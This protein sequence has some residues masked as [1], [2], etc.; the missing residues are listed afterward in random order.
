MN[1]GNLNNHGVMIGN[2]W[3][4]VIT[5]VQCVNINIYIIIYIYVS[6]YIYVHIHIYIYIYIGYYVFSCGDRLV[7]GDL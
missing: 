5:V 1:S 7:Y 6:I 4:P 2:K 3:K